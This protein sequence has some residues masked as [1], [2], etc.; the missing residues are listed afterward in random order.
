M[1]LWHVI[2]NVVFLVSGCE[3]AC[4]EV[5]FCVK[6][7]TLLFMAHERT[8]VASQKI[9]VREPEDTVVGDAQISARRGPKYC[10][11]AGGVGRGAGGVKVGTGGTT[12]SGAVRSPPPT[13]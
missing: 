8:P 13:T 10:G 6:A 2:V 9:L 1:A 11:G 7:L 4:P 3:F 12:K 5:V